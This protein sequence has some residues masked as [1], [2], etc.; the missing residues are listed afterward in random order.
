MMSSK[1]WGS[2]GSRCSSKSSP[3]LNSLSKASQSGE[4]S[5]VIVILCC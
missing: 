4:V 1:S 3:G 2:S 5:V